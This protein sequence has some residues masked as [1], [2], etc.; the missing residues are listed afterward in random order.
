[1]APG[2]E[3]Y[4]DTG[5]ENGDKARL[6]GTTDRSQELPIP[7][8]PL[9]PAGFQLRI[10]HPGTLCHHSS[11]VVGRGSCP[12]GPPSAGAVPP[13]RRGTLALAPAACKGEIL[14]I[15]PQSEEL[16]NHN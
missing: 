11:T 13:P 5:P 10:P 15:K 2:A 8:D 9:H 3:V 16:K 6:V 4:R 14:K 7:S 1:M 12:E